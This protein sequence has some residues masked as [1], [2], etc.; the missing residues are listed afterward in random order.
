MTATILLV[1]H[2]RHADYGLRL[3]GRSDIPLT[4][5]GMAESEALGERLATRGLALVQSSPVRRAQETARTI[6]R[7]ARV[8]LETYEGLNEI[9]FGRWSERSFP[10]LEAEPGW[11]AWNTVRATARPPGGETQREATARAVTHLEQ[12]A[13]VH[14]GATIACVTHCDVIRGVICHYLGLKFDNLL[15]FDIDAASI[16]TLVIGPW[17]ARVAGMNA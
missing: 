1:R 13:V 4:A 15:R 5:K 8:E 3:S 10:A 14:A 16:S 7:H 6:A 12:Q 17:G 11:R 2:A 9:D